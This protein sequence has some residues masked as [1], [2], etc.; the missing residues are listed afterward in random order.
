VI[1]LLIIARLLGRQPELCYFEGG[2]P[3]AAYT[4]TRCSD[5]CYDRTIEHT[6]EWVP[7]RWDL[8][9]ARCCPTFEVWRCSVDDALRWEVAVP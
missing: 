4:R 6:P 7:L 3:F 5:E 1:V 8:A 9:L 2:E